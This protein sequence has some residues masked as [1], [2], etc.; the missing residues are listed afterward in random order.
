MTN[1]VPTRGGTA[2]SPVA[3]LTVNR[4]DLADRVVEPVTY[5][6]TWTPE[7]IAAFEAGRV[8]YRRAE[9]MAAGVAS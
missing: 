3:P 2:A 6:A 9:R 5:P 4:I 8:T 7:I 1:T